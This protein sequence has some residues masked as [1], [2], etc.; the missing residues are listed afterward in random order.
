MGVENVY[1]HN[2]VMTSGSID[3]KMKDYYTRLGINTNDW[4]RLNYQHASHVYPHCFHQ[5]RAAAAAVINKR[6]VPLS[7]RRNAI[8]GNNDDS[9]LADRRPPTFFAAP[10]GLVSAC[11]ATVSA[12]SEQRGLSCDDAAGCS[13]CS[14]VVGMAAPLAAPSWVSAALGGYFPLPGRCRRPR[15]PGGLGDCARMA[16]S[17]WMVWLSSAAGWSAGA[18]RPRRPRNQEVWSSSV[19]SAERAACSMELH[20]R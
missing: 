1:I 20:R 4:Q 10:G 12:F 14:S 8:L 18:L 6:T 16:R 13:S 19:L 17:G 11:C 15:H 2:Y 3:D 5:H 7:V 9:A